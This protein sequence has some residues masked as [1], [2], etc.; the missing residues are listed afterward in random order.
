V[1]AVRER[2]VLVV[3]VVAGGIVAGQRVVATVGAR[4]GDTG[5]GTTQMIC[6]GPATTPPQTL[7]P[8][9]RQG[10]R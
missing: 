5:C 10:L 1:R 2:S 4:S 7:A 6:S 9:A 3:A 8:T